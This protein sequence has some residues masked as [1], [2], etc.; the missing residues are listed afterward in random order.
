MFVGLQKNK[1]F[2]YP[3]IAVNSDQLHVLIKQINLDLFLS[4]TLFAIM[5]FNQYLTYL[6]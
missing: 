1:W 4:L 2:L 3:Q 6:N 5:L